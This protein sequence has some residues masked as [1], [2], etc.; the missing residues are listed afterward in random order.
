M[1]RIRVERLMK[2]V[3]AFCQQYILLGLFPARLPWTHM[4]VIC[5]NSLAEKK[6]KKW[7]CGGGVCAL[8]IWKLKISLRGLA[9]MFFWGFER[10]KAELPMLTELNNNQTLR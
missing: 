10:L 7:G 6:K 2:L 9:W 3:F 4:E 8:G 5:L 1:E